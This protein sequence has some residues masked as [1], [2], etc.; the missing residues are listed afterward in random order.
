[1][2]ISGYSRA[3]WLIGPAS[4]ILFTASVIGFAA[5]RT[6]GYS[7]AKPV[8]ELG[9]V[10]APSA[11]AFNLFG[12]IAPGLMITL[13]SLQLARVAHA[14]TG[15]ALL[16][17][18]GLLLTLAGL[19][20]AEVGNYRAMTTILHIVGTIGAGAAWVAALFWLRLLLQHEFGLRAWGRATPWFGLFL[21]TSIVWQVTYRATSIVPPGWGHRIG[22]LGYF[23][24][25]A[26]SGLL[27]WRMSGRTAGARHIDQPA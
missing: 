15:P 16:I 7:H 6:D 23:M 9:S 21:V 12:L 10:G 13:F 5:L 20:P 19:C 11:T 27:L 3:A 17:V 22:L 24:W 1:M 4:G 14:K 26:I 8:S 2:A 25:F 18:S